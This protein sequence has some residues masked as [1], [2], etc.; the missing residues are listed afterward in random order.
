VSQDVS[1]NGDPIDITDT[2]PTD[3][4]RIYAFFTLKSNMS[5]RLKVRWYHEDELIFVQEELFEPG[6]NYNWIAIRE[7]SGFKEGEYRVKVG[8]QEV[9]FKVEKVDSTT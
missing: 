2:F 3:A 7:P 6:V 1:P 4:E 8:D 9:E 5:I